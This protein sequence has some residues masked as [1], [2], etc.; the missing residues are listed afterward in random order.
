MSCW[1]NETADKV[2]LCNKQG[3]ADPPAAGRTGWEMQPDQET[4]P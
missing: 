2:H 1:S 4:R 3:L